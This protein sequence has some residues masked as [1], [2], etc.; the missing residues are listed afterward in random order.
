MVRQPALSSAVAAAVLLSAAC[1]RY[2]PVLGPVPG[3]D[4]VVRFDLNRQGQVELAERVGPETAWL[5]GRVLQAGDDG[6]LVSVARVSPTGGRVLPWNGETVR[7]ERRYI[8]RV[9]ERR[10]SAP[11]TIF[12]AGGTTLAL[13]ALIL[14]KNLSVLGGGE[15]DTLIPGDD[16]I[17]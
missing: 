1:Y 10:L 2:V 7:L 4:G 3:E 16:P 6:Y 8:D 17:R 15:T 14:G 13:A 9:R 11:R 5:E 12:A